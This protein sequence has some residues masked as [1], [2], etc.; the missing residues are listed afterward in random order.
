MAIRRLVWGL[1]LVGCNARCQRGQ[2][3]P[4]LTRDSSSS[5]AD[6]T[7]RSAPASPKL[8]RVSV[9]GTR[10]C[11]IDRAGETSCWGT[12]EDESKEW[13][14][15][16]PIGGRPARKVVSVAAADDHVCILD[17]VGQVF[18]AGSNRLGGLGFDAT[19]R[20]G[21]AGDEPC[22]KILKIVP[23]VSGVKTIASSHGRTCA[24][25]ADALVC[26]GVRQTDGGK[27]RTWSV[28][29]QFVGRADDIKTIGLGYNFGCIL[30]RK[31]EVRCWGANRNA[32]LTG[33]DR[34]ERPSLPDT[35][36]ELPD[37]VRD[38]AVGNEHACVLGENGVFCW[39]SNAWRSIGTDCGAATCTRPTRV[40]LAI[41]PQDI[42]ELSAG[43]TTSCVVERGGRAT[44]WGGN[45]SGWLGVKANGCAETCLTTPTPMPWPRFQSVRIQ[46]S[47][48]CGITAE[49]ELYCWGIATAPGALGFSSTRRDCDD[50]CVES[51]T[52]VDGLRM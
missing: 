23:G 11:A 18:C 42:I 24:A 30:S 52:L 8:D 44:C 43:G 14:R 33:E 9:S 36:V 12:L 45:D 31:G 3:A 5:D 51:P 7:T 38:I 46:D 48:G 6:K 26:W 37:P 16:R 28:E 1:L 19:D 40:N 50:G 21:A 49:S 25:T 32:Q 41:R 10:I 27:E 35:A 4:D 34:R 47:R 2:R 20:C 13:W 22:S 15:P 17:D 29:P 39:G